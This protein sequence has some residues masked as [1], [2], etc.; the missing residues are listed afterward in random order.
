MAPLSIGG[1][2]G[3]TEKR[4]HQAILQALPDAT[5]DVVGRGNHFEIRVV[6]PAF[7]GKNKVARQRLVMGAIAHLMKGDNPPVHAIDKLETETP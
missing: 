3:E 7:D 4:V 5:V 6:S 2:P 1:P